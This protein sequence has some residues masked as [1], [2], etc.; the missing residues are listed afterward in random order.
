[1]RNEA[2]EPFDKLYYEILSRF[3]Y[4]DLDAAIDG[5]SPEI[6]QIMIDCTEIMKTKNYELHRSD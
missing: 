2:Q 3:H 1:M 6:K 4:N 5:M